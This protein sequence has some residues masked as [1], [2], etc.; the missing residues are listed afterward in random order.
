MGPSTQMLAKRMRT[1]DGYHDSVC[2]KV[3]YISVSFGFEDHHFGPKVSV[4]GGGCFK[5]NLRD[6]FLLIMC[7]SKPMVPF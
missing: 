3:R 6:T 5:Q 2:S 4:S 7:G 1:E